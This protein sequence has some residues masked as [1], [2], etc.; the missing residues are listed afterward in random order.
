MTGPTPDPNPAGGTEPLG[1]TQSNA[2]EGPAPALD[3]ILE[4][5][6]MY[7]DQPGWS[8]Y[9]HAKKVYFTDQGSQAEGFVQT[10]A[11]LWKRAAMRVINGPLTGVISVSALIRLFRLERTRAKVI[12]TTFSASPKFAGSRTAPASVRSSCHTA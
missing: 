9:D 8:A 3:V 11:P 12:S 5:I 7:E 2:G 4:E 10:R 6:D 1:G